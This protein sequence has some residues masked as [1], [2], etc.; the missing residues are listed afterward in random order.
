M[1]TCKSVTVY[2]PE[3]ISAKK[4][5]RTRTHKPTVLALQYV[6]LAV[7]QCI[8]RLD[9]CA[10]SGIIKV[11]YNSLQQDQKTVKKVMLQ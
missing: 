2:P 1:K 11:C 6:L 3:K 9:D 5:M 8:T 7:M 4:A 10:K